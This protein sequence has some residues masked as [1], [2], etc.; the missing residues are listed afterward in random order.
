MNIDYQY[1]NEL[2]NLLGGLDDQIGG[3]EKSPQ[4]YPLDKDIRNRLD[5]LKGLVTENA[6]EYAIY[7]HHDK[8]QQLWIELIKKSIQCLRYFDVREPFV[9]NETKHPLA[10]G[11]SQLDAYYRKYRD[12]ENVMYGGVKYYRDHVVHVVRVWLLGCVVLLR[13]DCAYMN[14][15][16]ID[17]ECTINPYEKLSIWT[18]IALTHDL[19]YPLEKAS[20]IIDT[21]RDMMT[22]FISNPVVSMDL[23][24]NGVQNSMNDFIL[25]LMSSKMH[26]ISGEANE[27]KEAKEAKAEKAEKKEEGAKYVA[28]L[29][30]KY[31][32]KFQKSLEHNKHGV[33]SAIIIYK[34]LLYFLESDFTINEDYTFKQNDVKQFYIRRDI[35]RAIASHTCSDVYQMDQ[36]SFSFLLIICDD[37]Q[38][39]GRKGISELYV[40]KKSQYDFKGINFEVENGTWRI[41]DSYDI[42]EDADANNV[43]TSFK[44]QCMNYMAIFRDGQETTNRNFNFIWNMSL[45]VKNVTLLVVFTANK[46]ERI[47][48]ELRNIPVDEKD[49]NS[50]KDVISYFDD[51]YDYHAQQEPNDNQVHV[52]DFIKAEI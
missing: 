27:V 21:T 41:S 10:Y 26:K 19:G 2:T 36:N 6:T 4:A 48:I 13:N 15:I 14:N 39:W 49:L 23:S 29:Q 33:L 18:L 35:L 40:N 43:L 50:V 17:E 3:I 38:T 32:F 30:S 42:N 25:R 12:F 47:Q 16:M 7:Q 51:I 31:Y 24:F 20:K 8:V 1:I 11:I 5:E 9:N 37:A 52:C 44:R 45:K 34:L 22:A 28:R 46:N